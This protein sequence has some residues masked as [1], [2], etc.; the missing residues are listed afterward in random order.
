MQNWTILGLIW[1]KSLKIKKNLENLLYRSCF[2]VAL[3]YNKDV[4]I[5]LI[6]SLISNPNTP[7]EQGKLLPC[8]L[9]CFLAKFFCALSAYPRLRPLQTAGRRHSR[10]PPL[11]RAGVYRA[12]L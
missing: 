8:S 12:G 10:N 5:P 7:F 3:L 4:V 6:T 9:P 2:F 1:L 11:W